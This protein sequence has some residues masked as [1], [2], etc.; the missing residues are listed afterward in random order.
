MFFNFSQT[1]SFL[2]RFNVGADE[3]EVVHSTKL[4]GVFLNDQLRWNTHVEYICAKA[5]KRIWILR[6]LMDLD[7]DSET[8]LDIYYKEIRSIL[9]YASV[10]FHSGLTKKQSDTLESVQ[11]LV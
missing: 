10:V 1:L 11:K 8:I 7:L 2:P 4:L 9:E 5:R 6:R 3:L